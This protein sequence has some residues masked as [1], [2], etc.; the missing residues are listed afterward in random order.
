[1][2]Q[3]TDFWKAVTKARLDLMQMPAATFVTTLALMMK[4]IV[5]NTANNQTAATD[6]LAIFYNTDF[7]LGLTKKQRPT[8]IAHEAMH[9]ALEHMELAKA[10]NITEENHRR[11]NMAADYVINDFLVQAG[12]EPLPDW[13]HDIQYRGMNT[14]QVY[15]LLQENSSEPQNGGVPMDDIRKPGE[16]E[17][18]MSP[19][20]VSQAIKANI[21]SAAVAAQMK[22]GQAAGSVPAD[23][24]VFLDSLLKPKLPMAAHLRKF[25]NAVDKSNYSWQKLN[26]RFYPMLMPG[27]QGKKLGHI[28]FAFDMSSSVSDK[29]IQR[30]VTELMAVIRNLKPERITLVQFTCEIKSV[31][32]LKTLRELAALELRG[33]EY[34]VDGYQILLRGKGSYYFMPK[35]RGAKDKAHAEA[36]REDDYAAMKIILDTWID[37]RPSFAQTVNKSQGSTYDIV[38]I[39]LNDICSK[40]RT[41]EQ[42]A[43]ILYVALSRGRSRI[44]MTG[45]LRRK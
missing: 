28:A 31:H 5:D 23:V 14:I 32:R 27:L 26:R 41:L 20:E 11:F 30:Y 10:H 42:L 15:R 13:C 4:Q 1:M 22:G 18:G 3:H 39:D 6:G 17:P 36:V 8:L 45:D 40:C 43:R 21:T 44:I 29:D 12:F 16:S 2:E 38:M 24:Q 34:G 37:L 33:R 25:F 35:H 7:F 19:G 9:A